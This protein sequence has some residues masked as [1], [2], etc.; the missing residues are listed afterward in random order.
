MRPPSRRGL[1]VGGTQGEAVHCHRL[2][3]YVCHTDSREDRLAVTSPLLAD[4]AKSSS[5]HSKNQLLLSSVELSR[6]VRRAQ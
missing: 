4:E 6:S 2:D 5:T 1:G 3:L